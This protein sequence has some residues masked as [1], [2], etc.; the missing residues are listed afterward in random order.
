MIL[1]ESP[2]Y[3]VP[4]N[5]FSRENFVEY[6][7]YYVTKAPGKKGQFAMLRAN[8]GDAL[9][10]VSDKGC[11]MCVTVHQARNE[12]VYIGKLIKEESV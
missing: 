9:L 5:S 6:R 4:G 3:I 11:P 2:V 8:R 1:Y 10:F 7:P 12:D